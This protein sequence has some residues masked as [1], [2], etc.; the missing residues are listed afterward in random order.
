MFAMVCESACSG[1]SA[2]PTT[3]IVTRK[4]AMARAELTASW[5]MIPSQISAI[6]SFGCDV[7]TSDC[8]FPWTVIG[9]LTAVVSG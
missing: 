5:V 6:S 4:S 8:G 2:R 1:A 7:I 9:T 3:I